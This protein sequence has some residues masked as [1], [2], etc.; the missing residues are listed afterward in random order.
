[1]PRQESLSLH[2]AIRRYL[3]N[4]S[5][6]EL[7]RILGRLP[8]GA[9]LKRRR[10]GGKALDYWTLDEQKLLGKNPDDEVAKKVGRS[11]Y[12]VATRRRKAGIPTPTPYQRPWTGRELKLVGSKPDR[13]IAR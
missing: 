12:A 3:E 2:L 1:M 6:R 4:K 10:S 11:E 9:R 13:E 8:G 7:T 5:D